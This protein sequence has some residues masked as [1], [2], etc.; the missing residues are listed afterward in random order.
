MRA[1]FPIGN[2]GIPIGGLGVSICVAV[3]CNNDRSI[4][5]VSDG[6]ADFGDFS[7][8]GIAL[9]LEI[10]S[11]DCIILFAGNDMEYAPT[12]LDAARKKC[13]SGESEDRKFCGPELAALYIHEA[14]L[15][16]LQKQIENKVLRRHGFTLKSFRETGKDSLTTDVFASFHHRIEQVRISLQFMVCGFEEK[17]DKKR[18]PSPKIITVSGVDAPEDRSEIGMWAIGSGKHLAMSSLMFA[19]DNRRLGSDTSL[20]RGVY[21][22]L[23]AKYMAESNNLVG[24]HTATVIVEPDR[25]IA[26]REYVTNRIKKAWKRFGAPK[27]PKEVTRLV[28]PDFLFD[29]RV[30]E[31]KKK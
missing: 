11:P 13:Y 12:V 18:N 17:P 9:K 6:K 2:L 16:L 21:S 15:E 1:L 8:D 29:V 7:A 20:A 28:P 25:L 4:V 31:R 26:A 27:I 3:V 10:F 22:A 19:V 14:Y 24:R 23:E 30:R 5:C